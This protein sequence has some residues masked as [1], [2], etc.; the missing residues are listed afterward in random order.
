[1][2]Q[3]LFALETEGMAAAIDYTFYPAPV[4][5]SFGNCSD[6]IFNATWEKTSLG[7]FSDCGG[8]LLESC[9]VTHM[10]PGDTPCPLKLLKFLHQY[11]GL[12]PEGPGSFKSCGGTAADCLAAAGFSPAEAA[13][14]LACASSKTQGV[15]A[16]ESMGAN[17]ARVSAIGKGFPYA[18]LP[19]LLDPK[20]DPYSHKKDEPLDL[21]NADSLLGGLC[22]ALAKPPSMPGVP[23]WPKPPAAC[24]SQQLTLS[25]GLSWDDKLTMPPQFDVGAL[26]GPVRTALG[27]A[28]AQT[29]FL[30]FDDQIN[31]TLTYS[32]RTPTFSHG[33]TEL[34]ALLEVYSGYASALP[35]ALAPQPFDPKP[36]CHGDRASGFAA[37]QCGFSPTL[38]S[39]MNAT[40]HA[41]NSTVFPVLSAKGITARIS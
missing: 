12:Y 37:L 25:L 41:D 13:A 11:E 4:T 20:E 14:S 15:A 33:T 19:G 2:N 40:R 27:Q 3:L 39:L 18:T 24:T 1:V 35:L 28:F 8:A 9:L 26:E 31:V 10:C 38:A 5:G 17:Q 30:D 21:A 32:A 22:R 6:V 23:P 7:Q 34:T 16:L 36:K 29:Q